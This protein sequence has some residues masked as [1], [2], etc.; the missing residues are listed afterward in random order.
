MFTNWKPAEWEVFMTSDEPYFETEAL[1]E[2]FTYAFRMRARNGAG[3]GGYSEVW[4]VEV[5]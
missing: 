3:Y 4:V 1:R 5:V 2:G